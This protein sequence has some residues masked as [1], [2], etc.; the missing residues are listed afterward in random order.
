MSI[1]L[2]IEKLNNIVIAESSKA[3]LTKEVD[4]ENKAGFFIAFKS[5][6]RRL[7]EIIVSIDPKIEYPNTLASTCL[8]GIIHQQFFAKHLPSLTDFNQEDVAKSRAHIFYQII[9]NNLNI[10]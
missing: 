2:S 8:E 6:A 3:Y 1:S 7:V 10:K 9:I 4:V 5:V